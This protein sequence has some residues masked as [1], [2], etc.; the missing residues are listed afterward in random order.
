MSNEA[1]IQEIDENIRRCKEFVE[2][3]NALDR[4]IS[5]K[6]FIKVVKEGYLE[7]E[8]IRLVHLKSDPAMDRPEHQASV[9]RQIDAVGCFTGF[10]QKIA[11]EASQAR[12]N[13]E[14]DEQTRE[15]ILADGA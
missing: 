6:D 1:A 4:L 13:I 12:H 14:A 5:N 10:L 11:R 7:K 9:L 3:G 8:A 2:L 15:E